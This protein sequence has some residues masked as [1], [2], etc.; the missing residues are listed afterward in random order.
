MGLAMAGVASLIVLVGVFALRWSLRGR[1]KREMRDL[2]LGN[3]SKLSNS[4][5]SSRRSST[6][7]ESD[8]EAIARALQ[9]MTRSTQVVTTQGW[10]AF[11]SKR[12]PD[13]RA[14]ASFSSMDSFDPPPSANATNL[15]RCESAV[16]I[17]N[18]STSDASCAYCQPV[19]SC[20]S[21]GLNSGKNSSRSASS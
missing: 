13:P 6:Y 9:C 21:G 7:G 4:H 14:A 11:C 1:L 3:A 17:E 10:G 18:A 12:G 20:K 8:K 15:P 19:I 2:P 16:A 5:S